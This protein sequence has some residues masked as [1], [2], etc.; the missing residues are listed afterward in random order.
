MP[1]KKT[2]SEKKPKEKKAAKA[3]GKAPVEFASNLP[4]NLPV[5]V[6]NPVAAP[7]KSKPAPKSPTKA[8]ATKPKAAPVKKAAAAIVI[9]GEDIALRAYYIAERRQKMGWPGDSTNDW[10]E[11]ERQL[12]A[13]AKKSR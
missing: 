12:R 5:L 1:K 8:S 2:D 4:A 13:E 11:A 9:T 7:K 3:K 6:S 10:V